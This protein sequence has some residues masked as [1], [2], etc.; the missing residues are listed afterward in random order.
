M[1][2]SICCF[3]NT[4]SAADIV[5]HDKCP[6]VWSIIIVIQL[7]K[8]AVQIC[9]SNVLSFRTV[10]FSLRSPHAVTSFLRCVLLGLVLIT[11]LHTYDL[12]F[13][14]RCVSKIIMSLA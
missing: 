3:S 8:P 2:N 5:Q 1:I 12:L 13:I 11:L 10:D 6:T 7:K 9:R 4:K 14:A